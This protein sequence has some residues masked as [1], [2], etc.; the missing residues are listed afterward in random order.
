MRIFHKYLI[1][2]KRLWNL[3]KQ[4]GQSKF[5][6]YFKILECNVIL[7]KNIKL[8]ISIKYYQE[9]CAIEISART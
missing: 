2:Q 4:Q 3:D 8:N 9:K 5:Y 6:K 1:K 7:L